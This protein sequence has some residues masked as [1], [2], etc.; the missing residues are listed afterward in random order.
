M[1]FDRGLNKG[2]KQGLNEGGKVWPSEQ[3]VQ[4]VLRLG[5]CEE[6]QAGQ[7]GWDTVSKGGKVYELRPERKGA[8]ARS[9]R[10]YEASVRTP[11]FILSDMRSHW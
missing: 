5:G 6:E 10:S 1:T 2:G 3:R 7:R 8:G 4:K 9:C 11:N